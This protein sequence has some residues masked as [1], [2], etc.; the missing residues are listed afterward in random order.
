MR[1]KPTPPKVKMRDVDPLQDYYI[2]CDGAYYSVARLVDD[3]KT[4]PVFDVPLAAIDLTGIIWRDSNIY[5]LS[6]H[7]KKVI[8]ADLSV[9]ILLDWHGAI[10]DG[11]HRVIKAIAT[12]KTTIKAR[13]MQ[14]KPTPDHPAKVDAP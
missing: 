1:K 3:A 4:L 5:D 2:D 14:W 13:R 12:G 8:E 11:R 10:A 9:P 6:F 7:S